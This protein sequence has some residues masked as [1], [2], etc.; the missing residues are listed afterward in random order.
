MSP[1]AV[2]PHAG[3]TIEAAAQSFLQSGASSTAVLD[4]NG[5]LAGFV[6]ERDLMAAMTAPDCW[7]R[8]LSAVM[9]P[10]VIAYDEDTPIRVI[11]E[12]LCRVSIRGVIITSKGR[13]AGAVNHRSLLAWLHRRSLGN[14]HV[15]PSPAE[16]LALAAR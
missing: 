6:S 15:Y 4:A 10:N 7:R 8:P 14:E 16:P 12:F 5:M 1:L 11:Y 2:C 9:R 3:D 13:P